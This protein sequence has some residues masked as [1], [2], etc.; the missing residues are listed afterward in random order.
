VAARFDTETRTLE[1]SVADWLA[2]RAALG[3]GAFAR[4]GM[5]RLWLGQAIHGRY[6]A[7][8]LEGDPTY[9]RE[10][11][12]ARAIEHAGWQARLSGRADGLRRAADGALVVEE[13]K[14]YRRGAGRGAVARALACA[15]ARAYAWLA[16]PGEAAVR[17]EIVWI[18]LG[19]NALERE[20]V[21]VDLVAI[22]V[23]LRSALDAL[24]QD[25]EQARS[26][27][28]IRRAS[29][30]SLPFPHAAPRP[31]QLEI[32]RGVERALDGR[33][34]LLVQAATGTGKTAAALWPALRFALAN[35]L[36][37]FV[38]TAKN[39][40]QEMALRVVDALGPARGLSAVQLRA[41]ARMCANHERICREEWCEYLVDWS[42]KLAESRALERLA[43][44]S[45]LRPER[46][47]ELGARAGL[48]PFELT[49]ATARRS[50]ATVCDYNYAFDPGVALSEFGP[51]GDP[52]GAI[53][54]V[55][56][57]HNLVERGRE[58]H[59][60]ALSSALWRSVGGWVSALDA[61]VSSELAAR[62]DALA[63]TVAAAVDEA[64]PDGSD[65]PFAAEARVPED[66]LFEA[67][68]GLDRA[69]VAYLEWRARTRSL[70]ADDA[71]V[72]AYFEL[73]RFLGAL[74]RS[75]PSRVECAER[76][77]RERR[78]RLLC[79]DPGRFLGA[80]FARCHSVIGLSATLSPL[81][82]SR[83]LLGL[84]CA[85]TATLE[86]ADPFPPENRRVVIDPSVAT[87]FRARDENY[88]PIAE[89]LTD[90]A[91]AV[92]GNCLIL[93]PSYAFLSE[94]AARLAPKAKRVLVQRPDDDERARE[95]I[96]GAL[97]SALFGDVALL[98][99]CGGA[100]AEGVDYPGD[101]LRA[102]AVVGPCLPA[103][104]LERELL[105]AWHE[106]E[107]GQ[108]FEL[109]Y[110]LPGLVRVVQA[111]GRLIRS[112]RDRGVI[113]LYDHRFAEPPYADFLPRAWTA[114]GVEALLGDPAAVAREFFATG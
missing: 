58:W 28:E 24:L 23:E 44:G 96:L 113:A 60:P 53:L 74:A 4:G 55:D 105:R 98:A 99:V 15:Q 97:R 81:D 106:G 94:I 56:E 29:A 39:T 62:C 36:R 19:G 75:D 20:P 26:L 78:L 41:K 52:S 83:D 8:A 33:E 76:S 69:F 6:Q 80:V 31:A 100:F 109:A 51:E 49:L 50:V 86:L 90:F 95:A 88:G 111:A 73:L 46:A 65:G 77:A 37:V 13:I 2:H 108:G 67:R 54:I 40:Q 25:W 110:V 84:E 22:E 72:S 71:F 82:L 5:E 102:V 42:T 10:V 3:P 68:P 38:L 64:A 91:D 48:C 103:L 7:E 18:E 27:R 66:E 12:L 21:E 61:P 14:S 87:A 1:L 107:R 114:D 30:A 32:V 34:H 57:I 45:T 112:E 92:P 79:R 16:A 89:R 43:E 11:A 93:F 17:A 63:E 104:S 9:R 70:Q 59:S 47:F 35:D 101:T 85:R